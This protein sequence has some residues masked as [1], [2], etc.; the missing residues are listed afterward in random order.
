M[1]D[2][3]KV[4]FIH[5]W[6]R[7]LSR[8]YLLTNNLWSTGSILSN[9]GLSENV[10]M[11]LKLGNYWCIYF[12]SSVIVSFPSLRIDKLLCSVL[13]EWINYLRFI[14]RH[15][16]FWIDVIYS[17]YFGLNIY[18][19]SSINDISLYGNFD[20]CIDYRVYGLLPLLRWTVSKSK[21]SNSTVFAPHPGAHQQLL[22][23]WV[24]CIILRFLR[25]IG[26]SGNQ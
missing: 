14:S 10:F 11:H 13:L 12:C 4:L 24:C 19:T 7:D 21:L 20:D 16:H 17:K 22:T 18:L 26:M 3:N 9:P 2:L 5:I 25:M 8:S 6:N 15:T 1:F 23:N